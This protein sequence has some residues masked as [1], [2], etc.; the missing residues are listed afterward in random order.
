MSKMTWH[1]LVNRIVQRNK[2]SCSV[3]SLTIAFNGLNSA[4]NSGVMKEILDESKVLSMYTGDNGL[5][6]N[7]TEGTGGATLDQA[8]EIANSV[9]SNFEHLKLTAKAHHIDALDE[10]QL[11]NFKKALTDSSDGKSVV[12]ANYHQGVAT[13][14]DLTHGHFSPVSAF[15][16]DGS[17]VCVVD[18][19]MEG[20]PFV[21]DAEQLCKAMAT[22]DKTAGQNR[23]YLRLSEGN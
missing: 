14:R 3:A 22:V 16:S 7:L 9:I 6:S 15:N 8:A 21:L 4:F 12:I 18:P 19:S 23:G 20:L 5:R 11:E 10:G 13:G 2:T 1:L 17:K